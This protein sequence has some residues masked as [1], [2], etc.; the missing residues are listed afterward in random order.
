[1]PEPPTQNRPEFC[2]NLGL[3]HLS[4]GRTLI[5]VYSITN[6]QS[7]QLAPAR[8]SD[9]WIAE[10]GVGRGRAARQSILG[11]GFPG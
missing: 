5:I 11:A 9:R 6:P 4:S 7:R 3:Y 8:S 1:M 10:N 2:K